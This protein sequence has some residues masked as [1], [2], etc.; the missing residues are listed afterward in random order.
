LADGAVEK[1]H[2]VQTVLE[3][4]Q[5]HF[6]Y[7]LV[8]NITHDSPIAVGR[9]GSFDPLQ[10]G[11]YRCHVKREVRGPGGNGNKLSATTPTTTQWFE[12]QDLHVQPVLPQQI[13]VSESYLLIF[14][15]QKQQP[16]QS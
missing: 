14:Q 8:A 12:L 2:L 6:K 11:S 4:V 3:F 15:R 16:L 1:D 9:E 13:G 5:S 7:D 10:E